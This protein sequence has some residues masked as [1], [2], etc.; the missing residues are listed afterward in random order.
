MLAFWEQLQASCLDRSLAVDKFQ[1]ELDGTCPSHAD[2]SDLD[3]EL[4]NLLSEGLSD[5]QE[6]DANAF[7]MSRKSNNLEPLGSGR[8]NCDGESQ[9]SLVDNI[10]M[11]SPDQEQLSAA[12][13]VDAQCQGFVEE[14][15]EQ[16][17]NIDLIVEQSGTQT[18]DSVPGI[19]N[20]GPEKV[21]HTSPNM[22][23][24]QTDWPV[25][26]GKQPVSRQHLHSSASR[27]IASGQRRPMRIPAVSLFQQTAV[28]EPSHRNPNVPN[29]SKLGH[30]DGKSKA[31]KDGNKTNKA[32]ASAAIRELK[33]GEE[34][35]AAPDDILWEIPLVPPPAKL[36]AEL[37]SFEDKSEGA[38][39]QLHGTEAY[40]GPDASMRHPSSFQSPPANPA[41]SDKD[42]VHFQSASRERVS[43]YAKPDE[44]ESLLDRAMVVKAENGHSQAA[45]EILKQ[46]QV[47]AEQLASVS[48]V[49]Q[50]QSLQRAKI[51]AAE[52]KL[53]G[54]AKEGSWKEFQQ[55][56]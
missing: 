9:T 28:Q 24:I 35:L 19:P 8:H 50:A 20:A 10:S 54:I 48:N 43:K 12:V 36:S 15:T 30:Q 52:Q 40:V 5:Q 26:K 32:Q 13:S 27:P 44:P 3:V 4:G 42:T 41:E 25:K 16:K 38:G 34:S 46:A 23:E 18:S 47:T 7:D 56:R 39:L 31:Q 6:C 2:V 53:M 14:H 21:G 17:G 51:K 29:I 45:G 1:Q 11:S 33:N 55:V 22:A 37:K 49:L